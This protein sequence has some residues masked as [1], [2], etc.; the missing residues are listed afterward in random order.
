[1]CTHRERHMKMVF[2]Y[3]IGDQHVPIACTASDGSDLADTSISDFWP[4][5]LELVSHVALTH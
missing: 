4:P 5:E 2:L 3:A 1:M